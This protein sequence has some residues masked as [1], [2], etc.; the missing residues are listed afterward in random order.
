MQPRIE[1]ECHVSVNV[2]RH[3]SKHYLLANVTVRCRDGVEKLAV[4]ITDGRANEYLS[5]FN[6]E[7]RLMKNI[8][9]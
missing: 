1:N 7:A 5:Y 4:V 6:E 8:A 9:R 3:S 2:Q